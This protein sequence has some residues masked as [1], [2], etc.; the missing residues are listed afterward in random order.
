MELSMTKKTLLI[1][2]DNPIQSD[3]LRKGLRS[4]FNINQAPTLASAYSL[5]ISKSPFDV[6]LLDRC[7]PDGDG[8]EIL[9]F[10]EKH[11]PQT[12]VCVFS[13]RTCL[14]DKLACFENGADSYF[15]KPIVL[16]ELRA[17]LLAL[18]RRGRI[19]KDGSTLRGTLL[20]D[21]NHKKATRH[22]HDV[23]L[24]KRETQLLSAFLESPQCFL[25]KQELFEIYW[26]LGVEPKDSAIHMIMQRLR[27]KIET[28]QVTIQARYGVGYE[29][30][31]Q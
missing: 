20:L 13:C 7:L 8:I 19:F 5:L 25:S 27:R 3:A 26:Q 10:L 22:D 28:L 30:L 14:P 12:R 2:E 31:I 18:L 15:P 29:L 23:L 1:I 16:P 24:T 9:P 17:Q 11:S 6:V 4:I 21:V